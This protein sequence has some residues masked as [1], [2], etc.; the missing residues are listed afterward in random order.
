MNGNNA[1]TFRRLAIRAI[2]VVL[3]FGIIILMYISYFQW[4]QITNEVRT[5]Q[6]QSPSF[7]TGVQRI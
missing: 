7:E 1:R 6:I 2:I 4:S 3:G 5:N